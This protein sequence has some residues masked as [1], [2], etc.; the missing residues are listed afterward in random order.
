MTLRRGR[1]DAGATLVELAIVGLLVFTFLLAV[2][3][4]GLL[5]RD[6]LTTN[7]AVADA[8][9]IG[10]IMGP[11]V[12]DGTNADY[13]VVK[14]V[15]EGLSALNGA[16]VRH[17]VV[18]RA[19]GGGEDAMSQVP[20]ACKRGTSIPNIC[21]AYPADAAFAAVEAGNAAY[22][23]CPEPPTAKVACRYDPKDRKDGPTSAE[24]E[25]LGVFIRIERDGYTG[26]FADRWTI[27]RAS[28]IRLEPGLTEP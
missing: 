27:D 17:V 11:D 2:F 25:T 18:F 28:T 1:S 21:N 22:F 23:T 4:F 8:T 19:S 13:A 5:F 10:A 26:L 16:D 3:E 20:D 6:N 9:R 24:V 7:D 15:R 12:V 14:A